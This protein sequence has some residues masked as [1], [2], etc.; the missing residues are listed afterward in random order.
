[1]LE[2]GVSQARE[3]VDILDEALDLI[4]QDQILS[5]SVRIIRAQRRML[6]LENALRKARSSKGDTRR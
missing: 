6:E 4:D 3:A 1:V 5:V 2:D